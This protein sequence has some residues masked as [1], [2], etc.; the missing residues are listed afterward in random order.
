MKEAID[1]LFNTDPGEKVKE[2]EE[3]LNQWKNS[4]DGFYIAISLIQKEKSVSYIFFSALTL[5]NI[6]RQ[7]WYEVGFEN[8]ELAFKT[9]K[10]FLKNNSSCLNQPHY[11]KILYCLSDIVLMNFNFLDNDLFNLLN[12]CKII[13]S[14][15]NFILESLNNGEKFIFKYDVYT[16]ALNNIRSLNEIIF[17]ILNNYEVS[18][19][20]ICL[21]KNLLIFIGT[22]SPFTIFYDKIKK[23]TNFACFK[24]DLL[25]LC[26]DVLNIDVSEYDETEK[27]NY[28]FYIDVLLF[29]AEDTYKQGMVNEENHIFIIN[30]WEMFF[31]NVIIDLF[32]ETSQSQKLFAIL[33]RFLEI[34][35]NLVQKSEI[36]IDL[37]ESFL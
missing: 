14:F 11:M 15:L 24:F 33:S 32:Y 9:L 31:K 3:I 2:S 6:I 4:F 12:E 1:H 19:E 34:V 10:S 21:F 29:I 18:H 27:L 22:F 26:S 5:Q 23:A 17:E 36:F 37:L 25:S 7:Y 20:W 35:P 28:F 30:S 16:E 13:H 8:I